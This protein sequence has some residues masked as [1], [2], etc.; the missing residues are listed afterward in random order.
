MLC[1]E[2]AEESPKNAETQLLV[3]IATAQFPK[4]S[5]V[6]ICNITCIELQQAAARTNFKHNTFYYKVIFIFAKYTLYNSEQGL[7]YDCRDAACID[8]ESID[9]RTIKFQLFPR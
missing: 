8:A 1:A 4:A 2:C 7:A 5:T 3:Y 9:N 6:S